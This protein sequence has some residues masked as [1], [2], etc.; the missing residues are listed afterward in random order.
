MATTDMPPPRTETQRL[1]ALNRANDVRTRR[2]KLKKDLK[3]GRHS[4]H[5][6]LLDPPDFILTAKVF[7]MLLA[8]PKYGRVKVNI[9][10]HRWAP[11]V[12]TIPHPSGLNRL[13]NDEAQRAQCGE[14]L[15]RA[16]E[17]ATATCTVSE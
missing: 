7:D 11:H 13:L 6:L 9:T 1:D 8:V 4:I 15:R 5:T 10:V 2:A 12:V 14:V 3:A 16:L 17:L